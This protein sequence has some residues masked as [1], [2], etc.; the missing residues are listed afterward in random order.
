MLLKYSSYLL[1]KLI[2]IFL[3]ICIIVRRKNSLIWARMVY[4]CMVGSQFSES[5]LFQMG[6]NILRYVIYPQN[7]SATHHEVRMSTLSSN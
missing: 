5:P 2:I 6:C 4:L 3:K 1:I 7:P